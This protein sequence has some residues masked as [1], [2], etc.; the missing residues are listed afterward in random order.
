MYLN[1]QFQSSDPLERE[2]EEGGEGQTPDSRVVLQGRHGLPERLVPLP[3]WTH[4]Q[5]EISSS[6]DRCSLIQSHST[7][8]LMQSE[9]KLHRAQ[10]NTQS[11]L[12]YWNL[13][14]C[15]TQ[16][17][18]ADPG[19]MDQS[20]LICSSAGF[21]PCSRSGCSVHVGIL[22]TV[23][24]WWMNTHHSAQVR[25]A[26]L[27]GKDVA[28]QPEGDAAFKVIS[29]MRIMQ[30]REREN[31]LSRQKSDLE[32]SDETDRELQMGQS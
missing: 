23:I 3:A 25:T 17:G 26:S 21:W 27:T 15:Q 31:R 8:V 10:S 4:T 6:C 7:C 22:W 2:D 13:Q 32:L 28:S 20:S 19:S 1:Q 24:I 5:T 11:W 29:I 9:L 12:C 18:P 16:T 14:V 30:G